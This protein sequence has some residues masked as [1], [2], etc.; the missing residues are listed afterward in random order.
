MGL[1]TL[2]FDKGLRGLENK[3]RRFG[4]EMSMLGTKMATAG[5]VS[6]IPVGLGVKEFAS[7]DN[8]IQSL[9]GI[10][11]QGSKSIEHLTAKFK[12]LG[13]TTSFTALEIATA[14]KDLAKGGF[15]T[16]LIDASIE[17]VLNLARA[18]ETDLPR[19]AEMVSKLLNAF[20][21]PKDLISI[22]KFIDQL[23]LT[24][25]R[26]PQ[27]LEDLFESL[28]NFAPQGKALGQST[29]SLLAFNAAL[30]RVGLTGTLSGTQIRRIFVNLAKDDK[31][32]KLLTFGIDV[33]KI[34]NEGG[35]AIDVL[36]KLEKEFKEFNLGALEES[37]ILNEIFEVRGQ[38]AAK[39]F[40]Q[41]LG[42]VARASGDDLDSFINSLKTADGF[43]KKVA[44]TV[45][46]GLGNQFKLLLSAI[47]GVGLEIGE[48][49][50]KPLEKIIGF[51][52]DNLDVVS[53]WIKQNHDLVQ[54][55]TAI[56][57]AFTA[58]GIALFLFGGI[59]MTVAATIGSIALVGQLALAPII[60]LAKGIGVLVSG[61]SVASVN[62][63]RFSVVAGR[64]LANVVARG[65]ALAKMYAA[66]SSQA[67]NF[68]QVIANAFRGF[69]FARVMSS[70]MSLV[71]GF[72]VLQII[73]GTLTRA[74][75]GL[76]NI[77]GDFSS[78]FEGFGAQAAGT[79]KAIADAFA[80]GQYIEV[81]NMIWA[82]AESFFTRVG[83]ALTVL[84]TRFE[85]EFMRIYDQ[86][87][88]TF[89]LIKGAVQPFIDAI[90]GAFTY[91]S[92]TIGEA[93][94]FDMSSDF[95]K[96]ASDVDAFF[97]SF[98]GKLTVV[99]NEFAKFGTSV[100]LFAESRML[101]AKYGFQTFDKE[102][103]KAAARRKLSNPE[104]N[105]QQKLQRRTNTLMGI[106]QS[107]SIE[108]ISKGPL[109][110]LI[111][112]LGGKTNSSFTPEKLQKAIEDKGGVKEYMKFMYGIVEQSFENA[113]ESQAKSLEGE[114]IATFEKDQ[115]TLKAGRI[116]T[117]QD[118]AV[119]SASEEYAKRS[120][121]YAD[122]IAAAQ[123]AGAEKI[124]AAS[125]KVTKVEWWASIN[126]QLDSY[127]KMAS[128]ATKIF[129]PFE[130]QANALAGGDIMKFGKQVAEKFSKPS[131]QKGIFDW[132]SDS[133]EGI[134]DG[135]SMS[136]PLGLSGK[137]GM[138]KGI[139][140]ALKAPKAPI[141]DPVAAKASSK[142]LNTIVGASGF[143]ASSLVA[144][145]RGGKILTV[146][147][148]I[149]E[150]TEETKAATKETATLLGFLGKQL[151]IG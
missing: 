53:K 110:N 14:A 146:Q 31:K 140:E 91:L 73:A 21:V 26:S 45:D 144:S 13:R 63:S 29:E 46:T 122:K 126:R 151:G 93:L 136:D 57:A 10:A 97:D 36:K 65:W 106:D 28:K 148:K 133:V 98:L 127:G 47:S 19:A 96:A 5:I 79:G 16:G 12:E 49:L 39:V 43:A 123:T 95:A 11:A 129:A 6:L 121:E 112:G 117:R 90:V 76:M 138:K 42:K 113:V 87:V 108:D 92:T 104:S 101:D 38:L 84:Y 61:L 20:R 71:K 34:F 86:V 59:A 60:M 128:H 130:R 62:I 143:N 132:F 75:S 33:D 103:A 7:F 9:K 24:T 37:G 51:I 54:S 141:V 25:N 22:E 17:G 137:G 77:I 85:V 30:A 142:M 27:G 102:G 94:G 15:D 66:T 124:K 70:V 115:A 68:G 78:A 67:I 99:A 119:F 74:Y 35:T 50:K 109:L 2:P 149:A 58:A 64:A 139:E 114:Y 100:A 134:I 111:K 32:A 48:S 135:P 55:Y 120:K 18:T 131:V 80:A 125:D 4:S 40:L 82:T 56:A 88:G 89:N 52:S 145:S 23:V 69:S 1:R 81:F 72:V 3:L 44:K 116:K 8:Q 105:A 150:N 41:D 147:E 118:Q 107:Q 83:S